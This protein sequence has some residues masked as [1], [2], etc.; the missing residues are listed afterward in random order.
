MSIHSYNLLKNLGL[1]ESAAL[2]I[3]PTV[4]EQVYR[5]EQVVYRRATPDLPWTYI[6]SG[7]VCAYLPSESVGMEPFCVH[8][9][10][11]WF[12][13]TD[14]VQNTVSTCEYVCLTDVRLKHIPGTVIRSALRSEPQFEHLVLQLMAAR[15]QRVLSFTTL[16]RIH[17]SELRVILGL[18]LL[19]NSLQAGEVALPSPA[20][21]TADQ[22]IELPIK[23]SILASLCGVSRSALSISLKHPM[24]AGMCKAHYGRIVFMQLPAWGKL[25]GLFRN[26]SV[27]L[28]NASAPRLV[29]QAMEFAHAA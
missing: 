15:H 7:L 3:L 10:G 23:Q 8:P 20:V 6:A 22:T 9:K 17:T 1:S 4:N 27:D 25:L 18:T 2:R 28:S 19:V 29:K 13:E 12:G 21:A 24:D 5:A 16:S 26:S 11:D 14:V